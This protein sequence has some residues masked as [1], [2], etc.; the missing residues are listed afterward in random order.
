LTVS[1]SE[2][3][4]S[5]VPAGAFSR[6]DRSSLQIGGL[7]TTLSA[8]AGYLLTGSRGQLAAN[9]FSTTRYYAEM[10]ETQ[11]VGHSAGLGF[12]A[13]LPGRF[14][15]FANQ[16]ASY[17]P[18]Y[19]YD[20]F[21]SEAEVGPGD[22]AAIQPEYVIG[23]FESYN[24][25]TTA[26]LR[27]EL[28]RRS[29][30]VA[31]GDFTY[32]DRLHETIAW[33]DVSGYRLSAGYSTGPTRNTKLAGTGRYRSAD[34]GYAGDGTVTEVGAE[35]RWDYT[36]RLSATRSA[37]FNVTLGLSGA[38]FPRQFSEVGGFTRQ[39]RAVGDV[40]ASYPIA[41]TWF[42]RGNFRRGL[43]YV[44]DLPEPVFANAFSGEVEGL[45]T[46]RLD[47]RASAR[48]SSGESALRQDGFWFDTYTGDLRV[49]YAL[50]RKLAAFADYF[51][52][53][54]D[55]KGDPRLLVGIPPTLERSG[56]RAGL[57]L[58]V[59]VLPR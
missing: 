18:T 13:R 2:G 29:G 26:T 27:R 45:I 55:F 35:L 59:P 31:S 1:V 36:R 42:A 15:L 24:Y 38:D 25:I 52:Y 30:I 48:Y 5:D 8:T 7:S 50:T 19:F 20:V 57:M 14:S 6:L 49:R 54:Y 21:P 56:I 11:S 43:D 23:N 53:Y 16:S 51:Y 47:V 32:T 34:Y 33:R 28:T 46:R 40:G 22:A 39:Y 9:V 37:T 3:Y 4:D 12:D 58:W 44:P 41:R 10:R 17:S